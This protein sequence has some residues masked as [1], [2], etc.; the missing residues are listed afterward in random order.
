M[1]RADAVYGGWLTR[2]EDIEEKKRGLPGLK[3]QS[4]R[5]QAWEEPWVGS[6]RCMLVLFYISIAC[7]SMHAEALL[8]ATS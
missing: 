2:E 8:N 5:E 1:A 3:G 4:P 6:A 7:S